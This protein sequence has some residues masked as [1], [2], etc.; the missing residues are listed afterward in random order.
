MDA[1]SR[2]VAKVYVEAIGGAWHAVNHTG[3]ILCAGSR[4]DEY[5][6]PGDVLPTDRRKS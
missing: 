3:A 2:T 1:Q 6:L 5:P 4:E